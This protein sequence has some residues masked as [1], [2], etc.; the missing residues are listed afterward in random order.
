MLK[1]RFSEV[2]GSEGSGE[3][4]Y[5]HVTQVTIKDK[6]ILNIFTWRS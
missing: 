6:Q 3:F 2:G 5:I 1:L 4:S